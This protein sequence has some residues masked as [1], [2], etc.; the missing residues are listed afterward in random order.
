M[1]VES[2]G[3][4]CTCSGVLPTSHGCA[5]AEVAYCSRVAARSS[6]ADDVMSSPESSSVSDED[7]SNSE[8]GAVH[9]DHVLDDE[10]LGV[11]VFTLVWLEWSWER[12]GGTKD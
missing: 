8:F 4:H 11:L 10:G 12:E 7:S 6:L 1:S 2:R 9:V 5:I 3:T